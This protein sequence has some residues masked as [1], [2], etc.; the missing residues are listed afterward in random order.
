M[1]VEKLE[2][3]STLILADRKEKV[4][5]RLPEVVDREEKVEDRVPGV[6]EK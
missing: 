5:G 3:D 2:V 6:M 4:V 1:G